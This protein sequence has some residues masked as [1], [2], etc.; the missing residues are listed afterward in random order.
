MWPSSTSARSERYRR[1]S[2]ERSRELWHVLPLTDSSPRRSLQRRLRAALRRRYHE[3]AQPR[4]RRGTGATG[5]S[6]WGAGRARCPGVRPVE[7]ARFVGAG[8]GFKPRS[9]RSVRRARPEADPLARRAGGRAGPQPR[10][11]RAASHRLSHDRASPLERRADPASARELG[12]RTGAR[13]AVFGQVVG[14]GGDSVRLSATL[15]DVA[16]GTRR[17]EFERSDRIERLSSVADSLSVV[18]L[19]DLG[20]SARGPVRLAPWALGPSWR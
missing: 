5:G 4:P 15:L 3:F 18:F 6:D 9:G 10:W 20:I 11:P 2:S 16:T 19:R 12:R 13:L 8:A 17:S 7:L 14:L 1:R